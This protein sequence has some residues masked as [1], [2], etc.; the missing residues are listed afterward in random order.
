MI[1]INCKQGSEGWLNEKVGKP[2]ASNASKIV[3]NAGKQSKQREG[4]LYEL[5]GERITGKKEEGYSNK[6]MEVGIER[7]LESRTYY[8]IINDVDVAEVGVIYKDEEKKFLCSPDGL[9]LKP[10]AEPHLGL[11]MKNVI[12]KT[13]VKYLL[14]NTLPSEYL[15][16]IQF[17]LYITG[18]KFWDFLSYVPGMKPL[19][20]RVERDENFLTSL[21]FELSLFCKELDIIV[22]K[23]KE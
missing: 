13:Q 3:T 10:G 2:S 23:I 4:Y 15:S 1:I 9:V 19:I 20:I 22:N 12:P 5:A 6:N 18:F 21:E 16:Q 11:E 14:T 8:E 17:S 7:E